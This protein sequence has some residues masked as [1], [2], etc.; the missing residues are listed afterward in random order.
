MIYH[1]TTIVSQI[2]EALDMLCLGHEVGDCVVV[3]EIII[4][5]KYCFRLANE[6]LHR[7]SKALSIFI[8]IL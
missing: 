7:P 3:E 6:R 8:I 1:N 5:N 4:A 2:I